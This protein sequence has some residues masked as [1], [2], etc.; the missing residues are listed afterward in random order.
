M[1]HHSFWS[2]FSLDWW[3]ACTWNSLFIS[4]IFSSE[5]ELSSGTVLPFWSLSQQGTSIPLPI[6]VCLWLAFLCL[7]RLGLYLN[8]FPHSAHGWCCFICP[9]VPLKVFF[10]FVAR[11]AFLAPMGVYLRANLF[12]MK[13]ALKS[14]HFPKMSGIL[15]LSY[16]SIT[17]FALN[18]GV[19]PVQSSFSS[20]SVKRGTVS[21]G[22]KWMRSLVW[23]R[24][25]LAC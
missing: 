1:W 6:F 8:T 25:N 24:E 21:T 12:R 10:S 18:T 4:I 5:G 9:L 16:V 15:F 11:V 7:L 14:M 22:T 17:I 2:S 20:V 3:L 19:I 23:K 13:L